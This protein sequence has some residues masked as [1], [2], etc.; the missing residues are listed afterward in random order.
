MRNSL[1]RSSTA[2][3]VFTAVVAASGPLTNVSAQVRRS[4]RAVP[5]MVTAV[6]GQII[7]K[8]PSGASDAD[9]S[10]LAA[11]ASCS[12]LHS[13]PY[14]P[15]YY[16]F[17]TNTT[18]VTKATR[19]AA[20]GTG[21]S[22]DVLAA[23]A[24]LVKTPGVL[25]EP[26]YICHAL[27][28][29]GPNPNPNPVVSITPT[30]S[31]PL[32]TGPPLEVGSDDPLYY[33][34]EITSSGQQW[35]ML[36]I[37]MP[38]AWAI[39]SNTVG[40]TVIVAVID[41]GLDATHPDIVNNVAPGGMDFT[42]LD[43][44][45]VGTP[46][47]TLTDPVG[48]GTNVA[49]II[50]AQT[51]NGLGVVGV[52]GWNRNGVSV[53][54]LPVRALG[55]TGSGSFATVVAA[56]NYA[57]AQKADV[58]N[59]S[60]GGL[61]L[62]AD[63][64]KDPFYAALVSA[65]NSGITVVAAAGNDALQLGSTFGI[66]DY[67]AD[68]PNV[69][70]VSSVGP[71]RTLASYSD[72]GY[73][74]AIAAPGGDD[75]TFADPSKQIL[76]LWGRDPA[77]L[78]ELQNS[79]YPLSPL[80]GY[81]TVQGTSQACPHVAGAVALLIEAG[82]PRDPIQLKAILQST[83]QV[84]DETP[85]NL[86]GNKYGA[87]LLDVYH[88]LASLPTI[89]PQFTA[90][91]SEVVDNAVAVPI[92]ATNSASA[93][94]AGYSLIANEP[95]SDRGPTFVHP[96]APFRIRYLGRNQLTDATGIDHPER[97]VLD[98]SP[99]TIPTSIIRHYVGS[100]IASRGTFVLPALPSG[101]SPASV[102]EIAV[103]TLDTLNL[104][105]GKY[106]VTLKVFNPDPAVNTYVEQGILFFEATSH[107]QAQGRT[108]F[109]SPFLVDPAFVG[110]LPAELFEFGAGT[111][112]SLHRYKAQRLPTD[113]EYAF[114]S[115]TPNTIQ[116]PQAQLALP[117]ALDGSPLTYFSTNRSVSSAPI[118]IGYWLDL[119][120]NVVLNP[121]GN[122]ANQAVAIK[123]YASAGGWNMIGDPFS[124][125]VLWPS[126]S[127]VTANGQSYSLQDAATQGI[128]SPAIVGYS[129][130]Q[131][132]YSVAPAGTLDPFQ[133]YWV[134]VYQDCTII[135]PPTA[136]LGRSVMF[137]TRAQAAS[138]SSQLPAING[139]R[140]RFSATVGGD[141]DGENYFG[142]SHATVAATRALDLPKPPS[143]AGHA[144]VRFVKPDPNGRSEWYAADLRSSLDG[145]TV[146]SWTADVSSDQANADVTVT[147]DGIGNAPNLTNLYLTDTVTHTRVAMRSRSSYTYHSGEAG[148]TRRFSIRS[149]R[150]LSAGPLAITN[151]GIVPG[152]R[153]VRSTA[154]RFTT[155]RDADVVARVRALNGRIV[156]NLEAGTRA[157]ATKNT[158]VHW[159]G[160]SADGSPLP[161]GLYF[162]EVTIT[163]PDGQTATIKQPFTSLY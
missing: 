18:A 130:G 13:I 3:A 158:T 110:S 60:L 102:Q 137:T 26:N 16:V 87:G 40:R 27:Q 125:S 124:Y 19:A 161:A 29:A 1:L 72:Y 100:T 132:V 115:P 4:G 30:P 49:G 108:M 89:R 106:R 2:L 112:F 58:I 45:P 69:I 150:G 128:I 118:G 37:H 52:A 46:T 144:Y 47:T 135:V 149:E 103:P 8:L 155:N 138:R 35:D 50:A 121:T 23:V 39:Q 109:S 6:P 159:N 20:V 56:V 91:L 48:H 76:N 99:A 143:G 123:L 74:I 9:A 151:F 82:A 93:G 12:V 32:L 148:A 53:K 136:G 61:S 92:V 105:D 154:F 94:P 140:A 79:G 68:Y 43:N 22:A 122:V 7:V 83:A 75:P 147:W 114:F 66:Y 113:L 15:L 120:R 88:A 67:P 127:V 111:N 146:V 17:V 11:S 51:G 25:A 14:S 98:I 73:N 153:A 96:L 86:G 145:E 95:Y 24:T 129:G 80:V 65:T 31:P 55:A 62:L 59:L 71:T 10:A 162:V 156:A 54:V 77:A 116:D 70:A 101:A 97:V 119:D 133:G 85:N 21:V 81:E 33:P 78:A 90:Q 42:P 44:I 117:R 141:R 28:A 139:W 107:T 57:V 5:A 163:T 157:E 34:S 142:I 63:L 41:S 38:Q 126:A 152:G 104:P 36:M 134:R 131:Y 84:L 160:R 64:T